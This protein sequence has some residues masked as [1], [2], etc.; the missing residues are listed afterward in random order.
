[1][2]NKRSTAL[3]LSL[4]F[5]VTFSLSYMVM[6]NDSHAVSKQGSSGNEVIQIQEKL[7]ELGYYSGKT[8]GIYG[9]KT[10][11]AVIAFQRDNNLTADGIVGQKTLQALGI[12]R[13]SSGST[14]S[15]SEIALL[16]RVISAESKGESYEGQV[17]VGAV[18]LN[19]VE[20]PSFPNTIAGVVYQSGAFESVSNGEINKPVADSSKRA[21]R[22]AINGYDP[23]GGAIY[24]YNPKNTRN[25]YILSRPV[26]TVIGDHTFCS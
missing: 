20:H 7:T 16:A 2:F 8:D 13:Q 18:I 19:R 23:S 1:M 11:N 5:A 10:K 17:A 26:I 15:E 22:D 4:I 9:S 3:L 14:Y 24:F 12:K 21:A 6:I 25:K